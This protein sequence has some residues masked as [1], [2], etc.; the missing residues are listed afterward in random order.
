MIACAPLAV[1]TGRTRSGRKDP[2][3]R[4]YRVRMSLFDG[5]SRGNARIA[6]RQA[7]S[8]DDGNLRVGAQIGRGLP[9]PNPHK[10]NP[11]GRVATDTPGG[12]CGGDGVR[13]AT[14]S[15]LLKVF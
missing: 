10:Q 6:S 12:A 11:G 15:I 7:P 9:N 2:A 3:S 8:P 13:T 1:C 4:V 5:S 14:S